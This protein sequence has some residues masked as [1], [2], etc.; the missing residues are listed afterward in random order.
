MSQKY[1]VKQTFIWKTVFCFFGFQRLW[2]ISLKKMLP[3]CLI[4][5]GCFCH[6]MNYHPPLVQIS[7]QIILLH[8]SALSTRCSLRA[9]SHCG[10]GGKFGRRK[11]ESQCEAGGM[12]NGERFFPKPAMRACSQ[13]APTRWRHSTMSLC[14]VLKCSCSLY[15]FS[16]VQVLLEAQETF[17]FGY[18]G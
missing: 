17:R 14:S 18:S 9:G 12:G 13:A 15:D 10:F 2:N 6:V 8:G 16:A 5:I 1:E 11:N 7:L 3:F 4:V